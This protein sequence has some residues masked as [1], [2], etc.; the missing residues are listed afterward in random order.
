MHKLK[1][2][3]TAIFCIALIASC[4]KGKEETAKTETKEAVPYTSMDQVPEGHPA[5]PGQTDDSNKGLP[6]GH[7]PMGKEDKPKAMTESD[8]QSAHSGIKAET[9][10]AGMH[11]KVR[12]DKPIITSAEIV[13][14]WK[15]VKIL[16]KDKKSGKEEE[17]TIKTGFSAEFKGSG[18][19][20]KV[21]TFLPHYAMSEEKYHS[22]SNEPNNPA[23][24]IELIKEDKTVTHGWIFKNF[25][26][27]DSFTN[28][29]IS[30]TLLTPKDQP[31]KK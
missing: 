16:V 10:E 5:M 8:V 28:D 15:E 22:L 29:D 2:F 12:K 13:D 3:I 11:G 21:N 19:T 31:V 4:S 25:P 9:V 24:Y 20:V 27:F 14:K 26:D 17:L 18:Y 1:L 7:P 30:L 6:A 23:A